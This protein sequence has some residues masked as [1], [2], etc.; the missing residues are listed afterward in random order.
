MLNALNQL[1]A[2]ASFRERAGALSAAV[3]SSGVHPLDDAL[4]HMRKFGTARRHEERVA[5]LVNADRSSATE[6]RLR[7]D[8]LVEAIGAFSA[9]VKSLRA[10]TLELRPLITPAL[11]D[12]IALAADEAHPLSQVLHATAISL[13]FTTAEVGWLFE[14]LKNIDYRPVHVVCTDGFEDLLALLDG[15]SQGEIGLLI[16]GFGRF[17]GDPAIDERLEKLIVRL[18]R[19]NVTAN[20]Y[21]ALVIIQTAHFVA[22]QQTPLAG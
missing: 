9:G 14:E 17:T 15:T 20:I 22:A 4:L 11:D 1:A 21:L 8:R 5:R 7:D 6:W 19:S 16:A 2:D 3:P 13:G 12:V 10:A 18:R